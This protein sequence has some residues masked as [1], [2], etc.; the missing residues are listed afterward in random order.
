MT[1]AKQK[2]KVIKDWLMEMNEPYRSQALKNT[3]N[4]STIKHDTF[5]SALQSAFIWSNSPEGYDYWKRIFN[6]TKDK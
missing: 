3:K 6:V 1:E 5:H 2:A 4:E